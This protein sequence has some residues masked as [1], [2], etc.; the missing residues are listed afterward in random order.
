LPGQKVPKLAKGVKWADVFSGAVAAV[1]AV[2]DANKGDE[3]IFGAVQSFIKELIRHNK[4]TQTQTIVYRSFLSPDTARARYTELMELV[5]VGLALWVVALF[6]LGSSLFGGRTSWVIV[7]VAAAAGAVCL[8]LSWF[9]ALRRLLDSMG[10]STLAGGMKATGLSAEEA[11]A[12]C[13]GQSVPKASS[14]ALRHLAG[15]PMLWTFDGLLTT[16]AVALRYDALVLTTQPNKGGTYTT[17]ICDVTKA[18]QLPG[19]PPPLWAGGIC[20]GKPNDKQCAGK[21]QGGICLGF[22]TFSDP[23]VS[24]QTT[25]V[26]DLSKFGGKKCNCIEAKEAQCVSCYPGVSAKLCAPGLK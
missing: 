3:D 8:L 7:P 5:F 22:Y 14:D 4:A 18:G 6:A 15:L 26:T 11:M 17:E 1:G 23:S 16:F 13:C 19:P 9:W 21:P 12:V 24:L 25:P 2:A 10:W 20:G